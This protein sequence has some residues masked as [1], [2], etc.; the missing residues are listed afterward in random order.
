VDASSTI[1]HV[2]LELVDDR[3]SLLRDSAA[4]RRGVGEN[5]GERRR[6]ESAA[7]CFLIIRSRTMFKTSVPPRPVMFT[8]AVALLLA[9]SLLAQSQK[10][11]SATATL[12]HSGQVLSV[13]KTI[14]LATGEESFVATDAAGRPADYAAALRTEREAAAQPDAKLVAPLSRVLGEAGGQPVVVGLWLRFDP[15]SLAF[16]EELQMQ[17]EA[18]IPY[19]RAK[20]ELVAKV[21]AA[22]ALVVGQ[23]RAVLAGMGV[24]VVSSSR[25]APLVFVSA[26]AAQVT[27]LA[28]LEFVNG[29]FA[30]V[31]FKDIQD[32]AIDTHRWNRVHEFNIRGDGVQVAVL[33]DNGIDDA[34]CVSN[35]LN[36]IGYANPA[37]HNIQ[38]HP[39][40]GASV[41][42]S[43]NSTYPGHARGIEILSANSTTAGGAPSYNTTN[44]IAASDWAIGQGADVVNCSFGFNDTPLVLQAIDHYVDYAVRFLTTTFAVA[45]GNNGGGSND[46]SSPA[47]S[48]NC[49]AVGAIND[50]ATATWSD[51]AMA[52]FSSFDDPTSLHG[53]REKPEVSAE[54]VSM[55]M[56]DL[57]CAFTYVQSGTSFAAP[58][59]AG[60]CGALMQMSSTLPGWPEAMKAIMMVAAS[61]NVEGASRLSDKDGA[62]AMN[63]LQAYRLIEQNKFKIGT[64]LPTS[65]N[66]AGYYTTDIFLQGGDKARVCLVWDS[67]ADGPAAFASDVLNADLDIAVIQGAGMTSGIV[68]GSSSS[69]DNSYEI[70][71]F[72]PPA[73]GWYTI[74]VNDFRFD[75]TSEYYGIAWTQD[76][77]GRYPHYR[78]WLSESTTSD[79]TGPTIGNSFFWLDPID[80]V[81]GGKTYLSVASAGVGTGVDLSGCRHSYGDYDFVT[82]L[83]LGAGNPWFIDFLGT[84]GSSGTTFSHR[85]D[86]PDDPFIVGIPLYYTILTLD[87]AAPDGILEI[88]SVERVTFWS[89]AT[90]LVLGDDGSSGPINLGFTFNFYGVNYTQCYVNANGNITF[91]GAD[92]DFSESLAEFTA[93]LPRIAPLWDDLNMN[94]AGRIRYRTAGA[95]QF[96][97]EWVNVPE[98][99]TTSSNQ[100]SVL[101]VLNADGTIEFLYRDCSTVDAIVGISPGGGAAADAADFSHGFKLSTGADAFYEEF[102]GVAPATLDLDVSNSHRSKLR[103]TRV[104]SSS[105]RS[106]FETP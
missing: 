56:L 47:V 44:I 4:K 7:A 94:I 100:N 95:D 9:S 62:G 90:D 89:H 38:D 57:G 81:N 52:T 80:F 53:D 13:T 49:I 88:G 25:F 85:F 68:L 22:N 5:Q 20:S 59:V 79:A 19:D 65:F 63:G 87:P 71:E 86:I 41:I 27:E 73:T 21:E 39:T 33:E 18:G 99:A 76:A 102:T 66:N 70:V 60:M 105:Y 92:G 29:L 6:L 64:F 91:G 10:V 58:G 72:C 96:I 14:D 2:T 98:Y 40:G 8:G 36:V 51:D 15:K 31:E 101:L 67:L 78:Q 48:F 26:T 12:R 69:W 61:H 104:S 32:D 23:A 11:E 28:K 17:V 77:D 16:R 74:R 97:V 93:G 35:I 43:M 34:G 54:G 55:T 75:G 83:L 30:D 1:S 46:V 50:A 3:F 106:S 84:W 24:P 103:F 37:N 42:G 45:A 82:D